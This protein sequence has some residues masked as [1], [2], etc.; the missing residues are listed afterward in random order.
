MASSEGEDFRDGSSVMMADP[1]SV[2][3]QKCFMIKK[4]GNEIPKQAQRMNPF[5]SPLHF[6]NLNPIKTDH[7][8]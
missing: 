6:A 2:S 7:L 5:T 4:K 1:T 8:L 3:C